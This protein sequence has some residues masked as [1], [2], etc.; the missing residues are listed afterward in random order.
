[1]R[2]TIKDHIS[3]MLLIITLSLAINEQNISSD[4]FV[5][6]HPVSENELRGAQALGRATS[7]PS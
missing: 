3:S 1:M 5:L 6:K 7:L 4:F 2:I